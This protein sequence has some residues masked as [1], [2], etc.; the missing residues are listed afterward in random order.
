[1][2]E[3]ELENDIIEIFNANRKVYGSR[4]IKV[5]LSKLG[6][7]VSRRKICKIMKKL[8]LQSAYTKSKFKPHHD[9]CNDDPISNE[10]ARQFDGHKQ[11]SAIVSDLTYVKVNSKW[12]Y[13]CILLDLFNREIIGYRAG[14]RKNAN[15]V[16]N[17]F[18]T[19]EVALD[20]IQMFHTDRGSEFNNY[21]I[22]NV[23]D[24]FKIKRL[25]RLKGFPY[26]NAVAE[27][28]F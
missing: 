23:L 12:N 3:N 16:F 10:L 21:L 6:K 17:A 13:V 1:L 14:T 20:Q 7:Q 19:V 11:Y 28:T 2:D 5:E 9:V 22:D 26:D 18:V 25:L 8:N 15:L 24:T 27:S 4:K